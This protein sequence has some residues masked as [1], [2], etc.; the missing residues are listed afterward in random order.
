MYFVDQI[1]NSP[2]SASV[3]LLVSSSAGGVSVSAGDGDAASPGSGNGE[4]CTAGDYI[5]NICSSLYRS[6][7]IG[8]E[9]IYKKLLA[10]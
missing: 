2:L 1:Y 5:I 4:G 6:P 7:V 9:L 8:G 10:V 3:S